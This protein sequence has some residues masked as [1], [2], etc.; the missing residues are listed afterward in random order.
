MGKN[1]YIFWYIFL[2]SFPSLFWRIRNRLFPA[3]TGPSS[4][5]ITDNPIA[6]ETKQLI[7]YW[8]THSRYPR[9]TIGKVYQAERQ[10]RVSYYIK[11]DNDS[12]C[13]VPKRMF[14]DITEE[15]NNKLKKIGVR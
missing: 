3:Y 7:H 14:V 2:S 8:T 13:E 5:K 4:V 9:L 1:T 15:R 10:D 6:P 12:L 11:D